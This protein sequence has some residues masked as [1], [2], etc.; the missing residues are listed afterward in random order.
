MRKVFG[1]EL[2]GCSK[3][4]PFIVVQRHTILCFIHFWLAPKF[5][6][7]NCFKTFSD[8]VGTIKKYYPD[9]KILDK[10]YKESYL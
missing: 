4:A 6:H 9:A 8:A 5:E 7:S 2:D 1:I 3:E 10:T